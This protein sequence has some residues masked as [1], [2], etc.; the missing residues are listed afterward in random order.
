VPVNQAKILKRNYIICSLY[1]IVSFAVINLLIAILI[2]AK[3]F[4]SEL[5]KFE[6]DDLFFITFM[7]MLVFTGFALVIKKKFSLKI[8][9]FRRKIHAS[10]ILWGFLGLIGVHGI[11]HILMQIFNLELNQFEHFDMNII[12]QKPYYFFI[13]VSLVAP[14][15]EEYVFRGLILRSL[16]PRLKKRKKILKGLAV[17]FSSF[18]FGIFHEGAQFPTFILALYL[19]FLTIKSAGITL[20]VVI[21]SIQNTLAAIAMLYGEELPVETLFYF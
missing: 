20:P 10:Q 17:F 9:K 21:H 18:I 5:K 1:F 8:F 6:A 15:Y 19:S 2:L 4:P 16:W 13:M 12:K 14:F 3:I 11:I 7:Q